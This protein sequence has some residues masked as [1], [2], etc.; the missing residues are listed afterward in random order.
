ME[1]AAPLT[2]E[3]I[4]DLKIKEEKSYT[5]ESNKKNIFNLVIKNCFSFIKFCANL[6]QKNLIEKNYEKIYCLEELKANK[7]LSICDCIDEVYQQIIFELDKKNNNKMLFEENKEIIIIIPVEHIKVKEIKFILAE[8]LK[9]NQDLFQSLLNEI[10]NIKNEVEQLKEE[11]AK[12]KI[13][14]NK[15]KEQNEKIKIELKNDINLLKEEIINLKNAINISKEENIN[16]KNN[17]YILKD[18]IKHLK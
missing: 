3:T 13:G 18:E 4:Q 14:F 11:K 7:F 8:I 2:I 12:I 6:N 5:I 1:Y 17:I 15:E 9:T 10:K 16:L